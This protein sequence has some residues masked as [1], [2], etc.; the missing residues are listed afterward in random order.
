MPIKCLCSRLR[1]RERS[2]EPVLNVKPRGYFPVAAGLLLLSDPR[3]PTIN[4]K[5][6]G[7]TP[8][9]KS[10]NAPHSRQ[11]YCA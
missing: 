8:R 6:L 11:T 3:G 1:R 5:T 4:S 2:R 10:R 7:E 9:W